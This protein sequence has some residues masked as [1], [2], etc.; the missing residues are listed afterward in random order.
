MARHFTLV[1]ASALLPEVEPALGEAVKLKSSYDEAEEQ[2]QQY[3]QRVMMLGGV[4]INREEILKHR[5]RRDACASRL[6]ESI[7]NI[8]SYGCLVKD[9]DIGLIDFLTLYRGEE[10]CLCWKLGE[11]GIEYWHGLQEG[12][13]GRKK[14]D[15]DFLDHHQGDKPN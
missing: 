4:Q 12:F 6:R 13:R 15:Q 8:Q 1:E 11:A 2:M 3:T 10:V 7:E 5:G 14:I 9:L